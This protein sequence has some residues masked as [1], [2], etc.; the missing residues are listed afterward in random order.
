MGGRQWGIS[1]YSTLC[2]SPGFNAARE[3]GVMKKCSYC[4]I[5]YSDDVAHCLVDGMALHGDEIL[6]PSAPALEVT[7]SLPPITSPPPLP[8]TIGIWV[9]T[10][11]QLRTIEL[12]LVCVVAVGGSILASGYS[13]LGLVTDRPR[14][15]LGWAYGLLNECAA[16]TL[17][18]YVLLRRSRSFSAIGFGWKWTDIGWSMV[19][20]F[21][22]YFLFAMTYQGIYYGG[23]TVADGHVAG[24]TVGHYLFGG[25]IFAATLV[26]QCINPFFEELI[27][28][29]YLMTEVRQLTNNAAIAVICSTVLQTSYHFYQGVPMAIAEGATFLLWSLYFAK[30][31]RI[32]PVILAHLCEDLG[33][34]IWYSLHY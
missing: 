16:L 10:D 6:T 34:T 30:T 17:L 1:F 25:G 8:A 33:S 3:F 4:G 7:N 24:A 5:E 15:S 32:M 9:I 13:L 11:R 18:R 29:A 31:N 23:L 27:V 12:L 26:F 20:L 22:G 28:R 21:G 2:F 14:G 19:L